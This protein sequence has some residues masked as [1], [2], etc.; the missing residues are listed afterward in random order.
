MLA[1]SITILFIVLRVSS[2]ATIFN[3]HLPVNVDSILFIP[4]KNKSTWNLIF[5]INW[6]ELKGKVWTQTSATSCR[7]LTQTLVR[8]S[9]SEGGFIAAIFLAGMEV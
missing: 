9:F 1:V 8:R 4:R 7:E 5:F 3:F 2:A 6:N